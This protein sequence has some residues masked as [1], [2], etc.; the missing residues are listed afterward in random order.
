MMGFG[1]VQGTYGSLQTG[2]LAGIPLGRPMELEAPGPEPMEA[3][4]NPA[5][6]PQKTDGRVY[7]GMV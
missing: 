7:N 6:G 1:I 4:G 2:A 5:K 3:P